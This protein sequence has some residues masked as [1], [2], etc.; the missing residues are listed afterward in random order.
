MALPQF[1]FFVHILIR[2][3][4]TLCGCNW[5]VIV[6]LLSAP[7][8]I[9]NK[10]RKKKRSHVTSNKFDSYRGQRTQRGFRMCTSFV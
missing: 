3:T 8:Y 4:S 1:S 5:K 6:E 7:I 10:T 9:I 2:F